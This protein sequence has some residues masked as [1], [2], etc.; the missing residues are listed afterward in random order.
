MLCGLQR[1]VSLEAAY[2]LSHQDLAN[3]WLSASVSDREKHALIGI[4]GACAISPNLNQARL[5]CAQ[6]LR[7]SHLSSNG[8]VF[9]DL[10]HAIAPQDLSGIPSEPQYI[11]ND[12]WDRVQNAHRDDNDEVQKVALGSILVLR[13]KLITHVLQF[14][15]HSVLDMDL[16]VVPVHKAKHKSGK[17]KKKNPD[18]LQQL[19]KDAML[20]VY[21]KEKYDE[22]AAEFKTAFKERKANKISGCR[23][24][25]GMEKT[26]E[27][28]KRCAACFKIGREVLYCSKECQVAN[29]KIEH[30]L[31]CGKPLD[32]ET[33]AN[34]SKI[35]PKPKHPSGFPPPAPGF[36]RPLELLNQMQRLSEQPTYDYAVTRSVFENDEDTGYISYTIPV[37]KVR[38]RAHRD[39]AI[40]T[41]NRTSVALI[42][43]YILWDIKMRKATDFRRE[44]V[45]EQLSR[46]YAWTVEGLEQ[47][48]QLLA[49]VRA[50]FA[51]NR[52]LL[53]YGDY[54]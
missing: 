11:N 23:H 10:L 28:F 5:S 9:L 17:E 8:Q 27:S 22:I 19:H 43:E 12:E 21:G 30:K 18:P 50:G 34:L 54:M 29:W 49:N 20:Q 13:T 36:K 38:F 41:G 2:F 42:C 3:K 31:I 52:P 45:V 24:C 7:V 4:A 15:V 47:G 16:P 46:E 48:L 26:R 6:E 51:G 25:C 39:R 53:S 1:I 14:I 35:V 44:K 37:D 33:A 32:Y 40:N